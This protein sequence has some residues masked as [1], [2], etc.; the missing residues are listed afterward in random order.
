[1]NQQDFVDKW[2]QVNLTER[3]SAHSHFI[4]LC[5]LFQQPTPTEVD[6]TGKEYT[7][8]KGATKAGDGQTGKRGWADV[9]KRGYFAWE[10]KGPNHDLVK[11][12]EQLLRYREDLE[13]P[14]LLIVSDMRVIEVHTNFTNSAKQIYKF[15]LADLLDPIKIEQLGKIFTDPY[16]FK[17]EQSVENSSSRLAILSSGEKK[18]LLEKAEAIRQVQIKK[19]QEGTTDVVVKGLTQKEIEETEKRVGITNH[20]AVEN[21]KCLIHIMTKNILK[22]DSTFDMSILTESRIFYPPRVGTSTTGTNIDGK[23]TYEPPKTASRAYLQFYKKGFIEIVETVT[24][25]D[26]YKDGMAD[27][28]LKKPIIPST[29]YEY[30]LL[31]YLPLVFRLAQKI[32]FELPYVIYPTLL[33]AKGYILGVNRAKFF[34][35][36]DSSIPEN[37]LLLAEIE[38]NQVED[39]TRPNLDRVLKPAFDNL[40]NATGHEKCYHYNDKGQWDG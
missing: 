3:A 15:T 20:S 16:S 26:G 10:Y 40:W 18:V 30:Y 5:H 36:K 39:L 12:Y 22:K 32:G 31:E 13:N 6:P 21:P 25:T 19:I 8:E 23:V 35:E 9:W 33:N 28:Q 14:P 4:D 38:I 2:R 24:L 7:F 1:M 27:S 37:E 17:K 29:A 11:A 34:H